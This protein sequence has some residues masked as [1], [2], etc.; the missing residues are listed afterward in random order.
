[1]V[2]R[3][4]DSA[5]AAALGIGDRLRAFH[6][7]RVNHGD[8]THEREIAFVIKRDIGAWNRAVRKR[9]H[10]QTLLGESVVRGSNVRTH[11][12]GHLHIALVRHHAHTTR[13]QDIGSTFGQHEQRTIELMYGAHELSVGIERKLCKPRVLD[14][15]IL[16]T[17]TVGIAPINQGDFGRV[18][19][20]GTGFFVRCGVACQKAHANQTKYDRI[21]RRGIGSF[22]DVSIRPRLDNRHFILRERT[23]LVGADNA[24]RPEA[25]HGLEVFDDG[26]FLG[27]LLRA[28]RQDNR[29]DGAE[30][31]RN[32]RN[33][34][35]HSEQ[36]RVHDRHMATEHR[37]R[38]HQN[39]HGQNRYGK[40]LR[41]IVQVL[42]Q[43]RF[44]LLGL[45]HQMSNM[46]NLGLH[47]RSRNQ[48]HAAAI[49][50]Q[51]TGKRHVRLVAQSH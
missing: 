50:H 10:A 31:L 42:L 24:H 19:H 26:V 8:K 17:K 25:F 22:N 30:R 48:H 12:V 14:T 49:R 40:L 13:Q 18:T 2:A 9:K 41:E 44:A 47:A 11:L 15:R 46:P 36:Q 51:R 45:V 43:W 32:S 23:R 5:N 28:H 39:A 1:M 16:F 4:H 29:D 37:Q 3:D 7:R 27:H 21:V 38:E 34:K 20:S 35:R 33:G 6:T